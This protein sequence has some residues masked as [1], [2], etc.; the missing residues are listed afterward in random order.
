MI[1]VD[2]MSMFVFVVCRRMTVQ[3]C[4][5]QQAAWLC[6]AVNVTRSCNTVWCVLAKSPNKSNQATSFWSFACSALYFE[7]IQLHAGCMCCARWSSHPNEPGNCRGICSVLLIWL[8][9]RNHDGVHP[10]WWWLNDI[11]S[12]WHYQGQLCI[13]SAGTYLRSCCRE[14]KMDLPRNSWRLNAVGE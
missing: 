2:S 11:T 10:S 12:H 13:W 9:L 3:A 6:L 1:N 14:G 7:K 4:P 8:N 5:L